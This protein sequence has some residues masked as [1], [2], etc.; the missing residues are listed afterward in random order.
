MGE[1]NQCQVKRKSLGGTETRRR[2]DNRPKDHAIQGTTLPQDSRDGLEEK[3]VNSQSEHKKIKL[4]A[5]RVTR[6]NK[7]LLKE[8]SSRLSTLDTSTK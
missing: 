5:G 3:D 7:K 1:G 8:I 4:P 2:L 6:H